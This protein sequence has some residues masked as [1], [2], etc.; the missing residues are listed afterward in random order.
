MASNLTLEKVRFVIGGKALILVR[1]KRLEEIFQGNPFLEVEKFP[2]WFKVWEASL[3][4]S[5]YLSRVHPIKD[6]L[7]LGA[8]LGIPSLV[9]STFGHRVLATDY[10]DLPLSF[11]QKS[12][13]LNNLSVNVKKLDW[14]SPQ[15]DKSFDLI[16]GAEIIYKETFFEPLIN[17]FKTYLKE[18]GEVILSHS[19]ERVRVLIP[20][21]NEAQREFDVKTS[22]RRLKGDNGEVFEIILNRLIL[23]S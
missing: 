23:K 14:L 21:L 6:I 11:V 20:F 19:S 9:A 4:L 16:V 22:I 18:E 3:I 7:E 15:L 10:E 2:L 13:Q 12:A 17:L 1:P 8:G 5:D